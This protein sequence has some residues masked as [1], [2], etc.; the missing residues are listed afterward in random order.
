[1]SRVLFVPGLECLIQH[2]TDGANGLPT[3]LESFCRGLPPPHGVRKT[4]PTNL[5]HRAVKE[6]RCELCCEGR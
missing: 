2:Y 1:M 3:N 5:L 6:G 4:G